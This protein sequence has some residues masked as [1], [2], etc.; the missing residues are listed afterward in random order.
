MYMVEWSKPTYIPIVHLYRPNRVHSA[1]LLS[2]RKLVLNWAKG[3]KICCVP[4]SVEAP[5]IPVT[6]LENWYPIGTSGSTPQLESAWQHFLNVSAPSAATF[7]LCFKSEA[8]LSAKYSFLHVH[9]WTVHAHVMVGVAGKSRACY[10][11]RRRRVKVRQARP[12]FDSVSLILSS[13]V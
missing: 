9:P 10:D 5:M 3:A 12:D 7:R 4:S 11:C 13:S 6:C 1:S 2:T 8:E